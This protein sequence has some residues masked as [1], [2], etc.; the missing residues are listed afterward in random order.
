MTMI[1][2]IVLCRMDSRRLPGK[3][4]REVRGRPLLWYVLARCRAFSALQDRLV[5]ATT[6]R[7][8]DD[9]I[10][11][12][13]EEHG[14]QCY[15]GATDDVAGRLLAA[16]MWSGTDW[17]FRL[18][19]DSPFVD[20]QLLAEAWRTSQTGEYDFV[21]NLA[22][23]SFPYGVSV[24]LVQTEVYAAARPRMS[25]PRHLEHPTLFLYE[26]LHYFRYYNMLLEGEN[27]SGVRLTVD[28]EEDCLS[29]VQAVDAL[30]DRW[31]HFSFRQAADWYRARKP[32]LRPHG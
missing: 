6:D 31:P 17:F 14:Y 7:P 22:P 12:F 1:G 29:F 2:G 20:P 18:N 16:A 8:V 11:A 25:D 9:P 21:T 3:T 28:T 26:N 19:G 13:C 30:G 10:A 15:R 23:R 5:V 32:G 4:L 27:L 24:E